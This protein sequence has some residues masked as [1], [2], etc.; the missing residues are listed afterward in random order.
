MIIDINLES[1]QDKIINSVSVLPEETIDLMES[2]GR[3][4][5]QDITAYC[6]LP[7][8]PQSAVDGFAIHESDRLTGGKVILREYLQAGDVPALPLAPGEAVGVVT[9]GPLPGGTAAVV[10]CEQVRV[11]QDEIILP[12]Q[13]KSGSNIKRAGED[14]HRGSLLAARGTCISPALIALLAAFGY[15]KV[16]VFC[17]PR[18]SVLSLGRQIVP[19]NTSPHPGQLRDSNGPLLAS[20]IHHDGGKITD[21]KLAG[22]NN[23]N[24]VRNLMLKLLQDS[25]VVITTG[26]TFSGEFDE[27]RSL[28]SNINAKMLF[29][30]TQIQPGRHNAAG[31]INSILIISLSGNPASCFVGYHV[32]ASPVIR[33]LQGMNPYPKYYSALCTNSFAKKTGTRRF[34]RGHAACDSEGW[35]VT[36]L[37]GQKPSMIRSLIECNALIDLPA[38]HAPFDAGTQVSIMLIS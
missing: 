18:V 3:V 36:V 10:M 32:L 30:G 6:S 29:W 15:E 20:L 26:G 7:D 34:V 22:S 16:R 24:E 38:G 4:I 1:A 23:C 31:I 8:C 2:A 33:A 17:R 25:D 14:F 37:P 9:G 11:W 5:S 12:G 13:I 27:V 28:F 35:K 21:V 19:F